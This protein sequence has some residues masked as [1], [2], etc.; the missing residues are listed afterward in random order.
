MP[1]ICNKGILFTC[2]VMHPSPVSFPYHPA[3]PSLDFHPSSAAPK[4][5]HPTLIPRT[6]RPL[7]IVFLPLSKLSVVSSAAIAIHVTQAAG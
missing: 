3:A 1:H 2:P 6:L 7:M 4:P 5:C